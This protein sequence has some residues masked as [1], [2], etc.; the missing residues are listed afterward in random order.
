[1]I[2][3]TIRDIA[4]I[5]IAIQSI[6]IG[7][8]LGVLV[9][10]IWRLVKMLQNEVQPILKDAQDTVGTVRGTT[11]F[12]SE[13]VVNPVVKTSS[14]IVGMRQAVRSLTADLRP[15]QRRKAPRAAKPVEEHE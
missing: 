6:V 13:N 7:V 12:V 4:I 10:Q 8:L 14:A 9:W 2:A 15:P 11:A 1:M 3:A 5:I